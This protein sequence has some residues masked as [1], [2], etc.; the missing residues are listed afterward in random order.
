MTAPLHKFTSHIDGKNAAV[1]IYPDRIEWDRSGGVSKGKMAL[2]AMTVGMSLLATGVNSKKSSTEMIP[3]RSISSIA[4]K[5]D[6]MMNTLVQVITSGNT[7]DF[8]VSHSEAKTVRDI[9]NQ[10][11]TGTH[12]ETSTPPAS[13]APPAE[14][15]PPVDLVAQIQSLASLRDAGVLSEEEFASKKSELLGRI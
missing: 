7:I 2:G 14:S 4:T 15:A 8:R 5:R 10:L 12:P 3:V 1:S 9:L 13:V 6:G 11:I